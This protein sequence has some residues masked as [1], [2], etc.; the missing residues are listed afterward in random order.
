MKAT[1]RTGKVTEGRAEATDKTAETMEGSR[2]V[3]SSLE[4]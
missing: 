3:T 2:Y 1:D 4:N